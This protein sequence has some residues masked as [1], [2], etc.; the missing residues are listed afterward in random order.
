MEDIIVSV[1][2]MSSY[3]P[4][5]P[6]PSGRKPMP[7]WVKV[8][9]GLGVLM[10]LGV[11]GI[12][13]VT[14]YFVQKIT[15]EPGGVIAAAVRMANPDYEILSVNEKTRT[16]VVRHKK[17]GKEGPI[18][19]ERLRDG[20]IHPSDIG[21]S[22]EEAGVRELPEWLQYPGATEVAKAGGER[23]VQATLETDDS[24]DKVFG[25]Y[26]EQLEAKQYNVTSIGMTKTLVGKDRSGKG[27]ITVQVLPTPDKGSES[28]GTRV[29]VVMQ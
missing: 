14:Y 26:K 23:A 12:V 9:L 8:L 29:L 11:V 3:Q 17:T 27:S 4:Q 16:M 18:A 5:M 1:V 2:K 13:G 28:A 24:P 7:V 21:L 6:P 19:F 15:N 22:N 20:A 25:Y 10:I